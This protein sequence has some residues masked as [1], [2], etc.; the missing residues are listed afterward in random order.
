MAS[1]EYYDIAYG[2]RDLAKELNRSDAINTIDSEIKKMKFDEL[3]KNINYSYISKTNKNKEENKDKYKPSKKKTILETENLEDDT[4][5]NNN[6]YNDD[7]TINDK[8]NI[9]NYEEDGF[10]N[11]LSFNDFL[12]EAEIIL[13]DNAFDFDINEWEKENQ[14]EIDEELN[15]SSINNIQ[16]SK[17]IK[18][19][20]TPDR[21]KEI[22]NKI[23]VS[24]FNIVN[25]WKTNQ[26]KKKNNLTDEDLKN[27]LRTLTEQD[28]KTNSIAI[29][30]SKNE[31]IIF[32][33]E[34]NIKNLNGVDLYIKLDYDSIENSPVIVISFH[35]KKKKLNSPYEVNNTDNDWYDN[36]WTL[37][38]EDDI[39]NYEEDEPITP[40]Q[41]AFA[42]ELREFLQSLID[43]EEAMMEEG[44]GSELEEKFTS[45]QSLIKHFQK[46]CLANVPGRVSTK[47][48][49]YYDFNT[50]K[51]YF[52]YEQRMNL[53]FK[54]G[55]EGHYDFINNFYDTNEVNKKFTTLFEGNRYLFISGIFG[56]RNSRGT[57]HLGIHSFSSDVTT[58]YKGEN[59]IDICIMTQSPKTITLYPVDAT[60]LKKEIVRI[61]NKYSPLLVTPSR[62]DKKLLETSLKDNKLDYLDKLD[63][64]SNGIYSLNTGW[65]KHPVQ[66]D[67]PDI[68]MEEFEKEFKVWEDK[69]FDLLDELE[70]QNDTLNEV[71]EKQ[72]ELDLVKNKGIKNKI[73]FIE[74][75][76]DCPMIDFINSIE[77]EKLKTKTIKNIYKLAD[78]RNKARPPLSEY[79]DDGIFELRTKFSS[80]ITRAFYFFIWGD[81]I[82]MTNGYIKKSQKLDI[83][84]FNKAKKLMNDYLKSKANLKESKDNISTISI[85]DYL[86]DCLKNEEFRKAWY[87]ND[88]EDVEKENKLEE[89]ISNRQS[90]LEKIDNLIED[91]YNIR[92]EGMEEEGEYSIKNLIFKEFRNLGYLDNLKELRKKEISKELSLEYYSKDAETINYIKDGKLVY[93]DFKIHE[94]INTNNYIEISSFSTPMPSDIRDKLSKELSLEQLN[95]DI[96]DINE[97][98][99]KDIIDT[100]L[101]LI[102][103]NLDHSYNPQAYN[104]TTLAFIL[105]Y[106][107][108]KKQLSYKDFVQI[109]VPY[110]LF[111]N[112]PYKVY[113]TDLWG[114]E[115]ADYI[116][117][118]KETS[119]KNLYKDMKYSFGEDV[120]SVKEFEDHIFTIDENGNYINV[121]INQI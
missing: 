109:M 31:A 16:Q 11:E 107:T 92:K 105:G 65:V 120:L 118:K 36:D 20:L 39:E 87:S 67:I 77:N 119:L 94:N 52:K 73:E 60:T 50:I 113:Y 45:Q 47:N 25:Y 28:Y 8:D 57:V 78:L 75:N 86:K 90:K 93:D 115:G 97:E 62:D 38:D 101:K 49:I 117:T 30:N 98:D 59:T 34:T 1:K 15:E 112:T 40:E 35:S 18:Y 51:R 46:H 4:Y 43:N 88:K 110:I 80:N 21:V 106:N 72:G 32:I 76:S 111:E 19:T 7:W 69:Y 2:L 26:F 121:K 33:K 44:N 96:E 5:V 100:A 81:K 95:E 6:D 89:S 84:E 54:N 91:I 22:I 103:E 53:V 9:E 13:V 70:E 42:N 3:G 74:I 12:N 58:N 68:D 83:K 71:S 41:E 29:N 114:W 82:V 64:K 55:Y 56:L 66:Q 85:D 79:I 37:E 14:E 116:I 108:F 10:N 24:D 104:Y 61:I 102:H 17:F 48:N 27:I 99:E 23:I 63:I